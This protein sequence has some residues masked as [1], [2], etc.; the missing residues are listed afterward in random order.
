MLSLFGFAVGSALK[1]PRDRQLCLTVDFSEIHRYAA[2][3]HSDDPIG[4]FSVYDFRAV[5]APFYLLPGSAFEL[6]AFLKRR[7]LDFADPK[8][9]RKKLRARIKQLLIG[10]HT[11]YR[12]S[13]D[14]EFLAD[15]TLNDNSPLQRISR[16]FKDQRVILWNQ[17]LPSERELRQGVELLFQSLTEVRPNAPHANFID[18]QNLAIVRSLNAA[19]Q[20]GHSPV[21]HIS[22]SPSLIRVA[23]KIDERGTTQRPISNRTTSVFAGL[24]PVSRYKRAPSQ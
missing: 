18:A 16:L 1:L 5:S 13:F 3:P 14:L 20:P 19:L 8:E 22:G 24:R 6:N 4:A 10:Q 2:S 21:V 17:T 7:L 9:L 11:T 15:V 12:A 23:R